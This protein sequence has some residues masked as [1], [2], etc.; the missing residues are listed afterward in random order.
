M[1]LKVRIT[2]VNKTKGHH[3]GYEPYHEPYTEDRGELYR[4][5]VREYGRCV[6]KMYHDTPDG[7]TQEIGW[8][9]ESRD[10]YTDSDDT[11][12][13]E[14]WVEVRTDEEI[15]FERI[16]RAVQT[17]PTEALQAELTRRTS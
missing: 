6:S 1:G 17:I 8:V 4:S 10:K 16:Q 7:K 13:R 14:T 12:I 15:E 2:Y 9:F 5:L 11:Y 3:I